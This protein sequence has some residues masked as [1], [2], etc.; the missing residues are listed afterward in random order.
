MMSD[1][2]QQPHP[3]QKREAEVAQEIFARERGA[4][5]DVPLNE[6]LTR[7]R[8]ETRDQVQDE[9]RARPRS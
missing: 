7:V 8:K 4:N 5:R 2:Q 3:G 6:F 1:V 9:R